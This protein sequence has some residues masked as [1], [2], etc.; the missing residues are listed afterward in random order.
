MT[1]LSHMLAAPRWLV[2]WGLAVAIYAVLKWHSWR[3]RTVASAPAWRHWG[4]LLAWPGM[5][6]DAFL[7]ARRVAA[8]PSVGEWLFAAGKCVAG[9]AVVAVA[10]SRSTAMSPLVAG[11]VGMVG[12]VFVLH[13]G[14]FHLLSCGWRSA[15]VCAV[16]IMNWPIHSA[17]VAEFWGKRWNLAF[18]DLSHRFVFRPLMPRVGPKRAMLA[19]FLVSGLV[20]DLVITVPASGGWGGPT[21]YFVLQGL[22]VLIEHSRLGRTIGLGRGW[23]GWVFAVVVLVAP[24]TLLFPPAFVCEV[25]VPFFKAIGI[26]P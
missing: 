22:A 25:I 21:A 12:I 23:I 26:A 17:S 10:V 14:L 2:M 6:V 8:P 20:H 18:R 4:Y 1:P 16:P 11:W 24:V 15:G 7:D 3:S 5:D 19:S 13:F 9:M